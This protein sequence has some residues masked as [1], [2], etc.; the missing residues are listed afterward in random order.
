[1][2]F[3]IPDKT[4]IAIGYMQFFTKTRR[5]G[6]GGVLSKVEFLSVS[7]FKV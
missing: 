2:D 7:L 4:S 1:L 3:K 5:T 6:D